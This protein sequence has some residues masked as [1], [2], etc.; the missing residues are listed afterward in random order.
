[1][2][3]KKCK[4]TLRIGRFISVSGKEHVCVAWSCTHSDVVPHLPTI[5]ILDLHDGRPA[6]HP[7][8]GSSSPTF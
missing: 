7:W 3:Q 1:V 2:Y 6:M 4:Q 8:Q 5:L